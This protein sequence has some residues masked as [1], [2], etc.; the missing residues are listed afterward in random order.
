MGKNRKKK[1]HLLLNIQKELSGIQKLLSS[2]TRRLQHLQEENDSLK[3]LL[4]TVLSLVVAIRNPPFWSRNRDVIMAVLSAV[5][6]V[7][8][9]HVI[10][11]GGK[12]PSVAIS[13]MSPSV[14]GSDSSY[15]GVT[16]F[17]LA[18]FYGSTLP[19]SALVAIDSESLNR[20]LALAS[21]NSA[22]SLNGA[23]YRFPASSIEDGSM[24]AVVATTPLL[25]TRSEGLSVNPDLT[26]L[27]SKCGAVVFQFPMD[28]QRE[29]HAIL[30]V[31][32]P[33]MALMVSQATPLGAAMDA[34]SLNK[35]L[36]NAST[37]FVSMAA[38]TGHIPG[39]LPIG[40][41]PSAIDKNLAA[42]ALSYQSF[43]A[44]PAISPPFKSAL[45]DISGS[46]LSNETSQ[47]TSASKDDD[48]GKP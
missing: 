11:V 47:K 21:F 35:A 30:G 1:S 23:P 3:S 8:L 29:A 36:T 20:N 6:G 33:A 17:A 28:L 46:V 7:V 31:D 45:P 2:Q 12:L 27:I 22:T 32:S 13:Q 37:T 40:S 15:R 5:F 42:A 19:T 43:Y 26:D 16:P 48:Q 44:S 38:F 14:A 10:D 25:L 18:P 39:R 24:L 9:A 34:D 41:A 4:D